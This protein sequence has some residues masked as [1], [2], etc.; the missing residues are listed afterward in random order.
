MSYKIVREEKKI[1]KESQ[2]DVLRMGIEN[3]I[4]I[5]NKTTNIY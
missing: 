1:Y 4:G 5:L 2:K 3:H